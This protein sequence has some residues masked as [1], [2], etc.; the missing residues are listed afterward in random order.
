VRLCHLGDIFS[1]E[2]S[3]AGVRLDLG[4]T[5]YFVSCSSLS[6]VECN[7]CV[8]GLSVCL[9]LCLCNFNKIERLKYSKT[10]Q[11]VTTLT[12][13]NHLNITEKN[14]T[15]ISFESIDPVMCHTAHP[16]I[17][18]GNTLCHLKCSIHSS[19]TLLISMIDW[20][21]YFIFTRALS[22][23]L[24]LSHTHSLH[25]ATFDFVFYLVLFVLHCWLW[26]VIFY[27]R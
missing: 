20:F 16:R 2:N 27:S 3:Y 22:L 4:F 11:Y 5:V 21:S 23:S 6:F 18:N 8:I 9:A 19:T 13:I 15:I 26:H 24:S 17:N 7:L 10:S 12:C 14:S 1:L 25:N